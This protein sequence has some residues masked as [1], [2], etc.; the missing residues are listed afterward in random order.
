MAAEL[1]AAGASPSR[2]YDEIYNSRDPAALALLGDYDINFYLKERPPAFLAASGIGAATAVAMAAVLLRLWT[3]WFYAL[4]LVLFEDLSPAR[5]LRASRDRARG[6]RRALVLS[7]IGWA[8]ALLALTTG[9][10]GRINASLRV[11][12]AADG[13]IGDE[14]AG[15]MVH[16]VS[17]PHSGQFLGVETTGHRFGQG[18]NCKGK[19]GRQY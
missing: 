16:P 19:S 8:L 13:A 18:R 12:R 14:Q 7:I 9:S 3:G 5:A 6:H 4:P 15:A 10:T 1:V 11:R 17:Q 2:L